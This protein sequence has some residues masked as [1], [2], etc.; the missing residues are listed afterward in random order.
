M[1]MHQ[2]TQGNLW[3]RQK[4]KKD[5]INCGVNG[6][7]ALL[8]LQCK[9]CWFLNMEGRLPQ[10]GCDNMCCKYIDTLSTLGPHSSPN[11]PNTMYS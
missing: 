2:N 1:K 6:A 4:Q 8:A 10:Y 9:Q 5:E 7:H 3:F 11:T